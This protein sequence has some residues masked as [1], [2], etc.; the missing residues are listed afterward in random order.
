MMGKVNKIPRMQTNAG[1]AVC[2]AA[3]L[4]AGWVLCG[5]FVQPA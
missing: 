5:L 3:G 2:L 1:I 4:F